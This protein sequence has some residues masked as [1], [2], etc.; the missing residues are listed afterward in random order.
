MDGHPKNIYGVSSWYSTLADHTFPTSFVKLKESDL[1]LIVNEIKTGKDVE[2][3]IARIK[4]AQYGFSGA[5]FISADVVAPTD[6]L[7]FVNKKGAVHSAKSAWN[8]LLASEKVKNAAKNREFEFICIRP[9]RNFTYPREFRLFI[10]NGELK[11]MSQHL[12]DRAYQRLILRK[13]FW[14]TK[15]KELVEEISWL[16]PEK[17]IVLDIYFTSRDQILLLDFN[18][19]GY[20]TKPLLADTWDLN[21]N[22][23]F[24]IKL[25]Q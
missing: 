1:D 22:N 16:L 13:D 25:L 8:I 6:T 9:F 14:W 12:L 4:K 17:T 19:W 3:I 18:K 5:T 23:E 7:R 2:G 24:G 20:P 21:W 15:A 10:Y 11:L